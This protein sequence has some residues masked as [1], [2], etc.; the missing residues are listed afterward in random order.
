[1]ASPLDADEAADSMSE[2]TDSSDD[3]EFEDI[4]ASVEDMALM[5]K[6]ETELESN[7]N[8]Y[9]VHLQVCCSISPK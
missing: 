4:Q 5:T 9:D 8:L 3:S 7:P 1:M 2:D 6:L